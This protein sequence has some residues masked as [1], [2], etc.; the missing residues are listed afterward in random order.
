MENNAIVA[1][2]D[3]ACAPKNPGGTISYGAVV[4]RGSEWILEEGKTYSMPVGKEKETSNNVA[5]YR[6][7]ITVLYFLIGKGWKNEKIT[8]YGDSKLVIEQMSGNWGIKSGL[9]YDHAIK[10]AELVALFPEIKFQWIPREKNT[11]ADDL[12]KAALES[13]GIVSNFYR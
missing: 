12:S 1:Y 7:L 11:K 5:E 9:Y 13:V 6:G 2:F 4:R 8:I 3:G 10:A